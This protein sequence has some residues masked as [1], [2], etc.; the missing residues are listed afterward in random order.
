MPLRVLIRKSESH[1]GVSLMTQTNMITGRGSVGGAVTGNPF[2]ESAAV[3]K[4]E[5][6]VS[7]GDTSAYGLW[8]G[9]QSSFVANMNNK[10]NAVKTLGV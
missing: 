6:G 10:S 8:L 1:T 3:M 2:S 4:P 9:Q 5:L 7:L